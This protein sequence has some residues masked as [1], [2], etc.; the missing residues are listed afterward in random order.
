[1][2]FEYRGPRVYTSVY[3]ALRTSKTMVRRLLLLV[4]YDMLHGAHIF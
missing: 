3:A 1:M 4:S 2:P